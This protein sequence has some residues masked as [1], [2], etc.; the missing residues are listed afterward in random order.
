M[1]V[2]DKAHDMG[3]FKQEVDMTRATAGM[4]VAV[5]L[6]LAGSIEKVDAAP[7]FQCSQRYFTAHEA[8][9]TRNNRETCDRVIGDRRAACMKNGCWRTTNTNRCGYSRL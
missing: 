4:A 9:L 2:W 7:A 8:C 3:A 6:A 1:P 5:L